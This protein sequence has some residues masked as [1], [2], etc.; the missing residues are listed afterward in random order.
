MAYRPKP[1]QGPDEPQTE[2]DW[3]SEILLS[4]AMVA[5]PEEVKARGWQFAMRYA[6]GWKKGFLDGLSRAR[7]EL[8]TRVGSPCAR[9]G[10]TENV[11]GCC[12][13]GDICVNCVDQH[14]TFDPDPTYCEELRRH[15]E[16]PDIRIPRGIDW[17]VR[18]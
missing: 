8:Q 9:C 15:S 6:L 17:R 7:R 3:L 12:W 16:H 13:G 14:Y 2:R 11:G 18:Q 1:D 10:G 5:V 4:I